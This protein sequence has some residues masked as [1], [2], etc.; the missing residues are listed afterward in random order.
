MKSLTEAEFKSTMREP[1][2]D[3]TESPGD[4]IDIWPY[5]SSIIGSVSLPPLVFEKGLVDH[6]YRSGDGIHDHVLL[7]TESKN[8]FLVV[9][10]DRLKSTVI[11]HHML[12]LNQQYG[13]E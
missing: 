4:V 6:V 5:V 9:I 3:V 1:M 12:N 7:P 13:I 10:V 11:G 2:V 8:K